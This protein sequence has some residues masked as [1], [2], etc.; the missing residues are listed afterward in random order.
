MVHMTNST[1][2]DMGLVAVE[3]LGIPPLRAQG[4]ACEDRWCVWC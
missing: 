2:I 1:H 3:Y 4:G